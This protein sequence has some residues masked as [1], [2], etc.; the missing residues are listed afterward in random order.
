LSRHNLLVTATR[1]M[2]LCV[3]VLYIHYQFQ[4]QLLPCMSRLDL[5]KALG[6][7]DAIWDAMCLEDESNTRLEWNL[8][9][10]GGKLEWLMEWK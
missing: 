1:W 10:C 4:I 2:D 6:V 9:S 3:I 5:V 7:V 8:R